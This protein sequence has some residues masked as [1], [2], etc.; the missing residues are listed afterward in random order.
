MYLQQNHSRVRES[1]RT[2][3]SNR[4][5]SALRLIDGREGFGKAVVKP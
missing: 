2:A 4:R 5:V 3:S 1:E